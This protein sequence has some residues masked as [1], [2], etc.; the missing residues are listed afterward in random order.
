MSR[1]IQKRTALGVVIGSRAFFNGAPCRAARE[2]VLAQLASLGVDAHI[3]PF[4]AT[5]NGA[6][7]TIADADTYAAFF[8]SKREEIDGLVICLPNFGDEIAI[9]ELVNRAGLNVPILLQASNDEVDK[10][11]VHERRDAFCGK[12]SV[13]NNFYQYGVPFTETT[14]HTCDIASA[15]FRN[16]LDRFARVC[17]TVR[18]LRGARLGAIGA[19]TGAFQTMRYSEKLLQASGITVVTVDLSEMMGAAARIADDDKA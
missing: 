17:R 18:G 7:Q 14:S 6:V 19:R 16:D 12:L 1:F 4:E 9:A 8:R 10:V 15:E 2:E 11:S 5:V 13:S 3:L